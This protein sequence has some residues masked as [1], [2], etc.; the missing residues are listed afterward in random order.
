MIF[1]GASVAEAI[2]NSEDGLQQGD[3]P[4]ILVRRDDLKILLDLVENLEFEVARLKGTH[5]LADLH[6]AFNRRAD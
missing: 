4:L 5:Q 1:Q 6:A 3:A 2:F